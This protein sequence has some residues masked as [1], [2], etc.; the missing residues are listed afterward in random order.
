[1]RILPLQ[2]CILTLATLFTS[3]TH[4]N[5]PEQE[6]I[7][8]TDTRQILKNSINSMLP[9]YKQRATQMVQ[10]RTGHTTLNSKDLQVV[11]QLTQSLFN[12]SEDFLNRMNIQQSIE[13]VY[14]SYYTE[15]EVQA[16]LKF[17]KSPEGRSIMSKNAQVN[18]A[19][20]QQV[21]TSI[22]NM[23]KSVRFQQTITQ[24]TQRILAQLP[25]AK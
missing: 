3:I 17:L 6:L 5:S 23:A 13:G 10:Q 11:D 25:T 24:D 20:E 15:Q 8:L 18:A 14:A 7:A 19:V 21:A 9:V 2:A 12:T 22:G 1:M 16:Y 4:A